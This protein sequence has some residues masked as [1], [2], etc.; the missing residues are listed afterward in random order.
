MG[1][2]VSTLLPDRATVAGPVLAVTV[3]LP[4]LA[5]AAL[6]VNTTTTLQL[7]PG[8]RV[9][10]QVLDAANSGI[11]AASTCV[12]VSAAV[13]EFL[14]AT[15]CAVLVVA[16]VCVGNAIELRLSATVAA[17]VALPMPDNA[18]DGFVGA[19]DCTVSVAV[20]VPTAAGV[21]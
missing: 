13:P 6:G 2:G 3:T 9:P 21:N 5:P 18:I 1:V 16:M 10:T 11:G 4:V 17:A 7:P 19:F 8:S 15:S 14:T 20:R 12:I